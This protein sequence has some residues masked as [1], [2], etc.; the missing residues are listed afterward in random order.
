M[1][2]LDSAGQLAVPWGADW[3]HSNGCSLLEGWLE[4]EHLSWYPSHV[5]LLV[6]SICQILSPSSLSGCTEI[7]M[8]WLRVSDEESGNHQASYGLT[9]KLY[10]SLLLHTIG[11]SKSPGEPRYLMGGWQIALQR[12]RWDGRSSS[13]LYEQSMGK[14]QHMKIIKASDIY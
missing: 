5:S 4:L 14:L 9:L 11:Q 6:L 12:G 7:F 2:W 1:G 3:D 10:I 8:W 13:H